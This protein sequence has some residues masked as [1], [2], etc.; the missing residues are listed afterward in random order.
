MGKKK[1]IH[2]S[3]QPS[4]RPSIHP[5]IYLL[6]VETLPLE[7]TN[8]D[9]AANETRPSEPTTRKNGDGSNVLPMETGDEYRVAKAEATARGYQS[10]S[11]T[12]ED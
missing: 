10:M 4:N 12:K 8:R 3:V 1:S 6:S 11:T 5:S 9:R 7:A 2:P